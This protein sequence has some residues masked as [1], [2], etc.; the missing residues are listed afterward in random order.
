MANCFPF[1]TLLDSL[2]HSITNYELIPKTTTDNNANFRQP[3][4][5]S[6]RF[7]L[8]G[9]VSIELIELIDSLKPTPSHCHDKIISNFVKPENL[10][11]II[12][13]KYANKRSIVTL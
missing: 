11:N 9:S 12:W 6:N 10:I 3:L 5:I 7:G 2:K 13:K 8:P 1:V 4:I